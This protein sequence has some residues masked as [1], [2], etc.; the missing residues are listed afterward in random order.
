MTGLATARPSVGLFTYS[1]QPRGSVVHT[2]YLAEALHDAGWDV[3]V[4]ALDKDGRGLFRPLSAPVCL[5]PAGPAPDST[6]ALVHQRAAELTAFLTARGRRHDLY[7]AQD[8]LTAN[9]LLGLHHEPLVVRTIHHVERF[10][11]PE[12]AACQR[13]SIRGATL[14]LAVSDTAARDAWRAFGVTIA[15]VGNG[16]AAERFQTPDL[17]REQAW[18]RRMDGAGPLVLAVGGVEERKNTVRVLGA[19]ARLHA[20]QP[21]ARL[22]ILGGASVLDHG[23]YRAAYLAALARLPPATRAAVSELGVVPDPDVPSI[24]RV[25]SVLALPSLQEGFGL[26]ALE[27][28]AAGLPAVVSGAPPFTEYLDASCAVLVDPQAE[29]AI[30]SGLRQALVT[31]PARREAG[32]LRAEAL[33][34]ARVARQHIHHYTALLGGWRPDGRPA[35]RAEA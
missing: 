1:T 5:V 19:F 12:L 18:R 27:A 35:R 8:C 25:A 10:A 33:S 2:T 17:D 4:Y 11:D 14:C 22:W 3:T 24:M 26:A 15:R 6:V 32:R 21:G 28:L 31:A 23:A 20:E 29:D 16:V 34:W 9:A 30:A 13:R 7:H